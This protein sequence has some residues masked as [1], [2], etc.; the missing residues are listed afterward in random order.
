MLPRHGTADRHCLHAGERRDAPLRFGIEGGD[1]GA[2]H[3]GGGR[4]HV[5][6]QH[7]PHVHTRVRRLQPHQRC[8]EHARAGEQDERERYLRGRE[9]PQPS[10][11]TGRDP[12]A[13]ARQSQA[14]RC[15]RRRQARHVGEEH[16]RGHRET[17]ADPQDRRIDRHVERADGVAC[18]VTRHG[19]DQRARQHDAEQRA[20]AAQDQAFGQEG[21]PQRRVAGAERRTHRQLALAT[22]RPRED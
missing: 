15:V 7:L 12:G 8:D 1:L 4:R 20:G 2:E 18:G 9:N 14:G 17:G 11:G 6:H 10:I 19:A 5:E 3:P 22:N 16:R 21:A 13:A